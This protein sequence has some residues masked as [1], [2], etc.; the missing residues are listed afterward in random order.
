MLGP[1]RPS[2]LAKEKWSSLLS[3]C[4]QWVVAWRQRVPAWDDYDNAPRGGDVSGLTR[5][6]PADGSISPSLSHD[7]PPTE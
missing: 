4:P 7:S 1:A 5:G 6:D 2:V 3:I